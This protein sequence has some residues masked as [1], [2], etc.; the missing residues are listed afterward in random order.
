VLDAGGGLMGLM[1][2]M[3]VCLI[4]E[5]S[6]PYAVGGTSVWTQQLIE[7]LSDVDFT[8]VAI[9]SENKKEKD[10]RYALPGNVRGVQSVALHDQRWLSETLRKRP[11]GMRRA[12]P[13]WDAAEQA[14][15]ALL[16]G[17][18][19]AFPQ[20]NRVVNADLTGWDLFC[21]PRHWSLLERYYRAL[22]PE[23]PFLSFYSMWR[24]SHLLL[25]R[26]LI[27]AMPKDADIYHPIS[28]GFA[29]LLGVCAKL[30]NKG[31]ALILT[32]HGHYS[33]ERNLELETSPWLR[34]YQRYFMSGLFATL[35]RLAYAHADLLVTR[36]EAA[37]RP[38]IEMGAP[39][40]HTVV[41]PNG[42]DSERFARLPARA[43]DGMVRI[44]LIGRVVP[45][46]DVIAF[47]ECA[48][49]VAETLPNAEFEIIGP[50]DDAP[51]YASSARALVRQ[52]RLEDRLWFSGFQK[53][54]V[55]LPRLDL[56]VMSSLKESQP[57]SALEAMAYGIPVIAT[58]AGSLPQMLDGVGELVWQHDIQGMAEAVIRLS[59]DEAR[60]RSWGQ[61][62]GERVRQ[63]YDQHRNLDQYRQLYKQVAG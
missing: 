45:I 29:G 41:V 39:E 53:P 8:V 52:L 58:R 7:T 26:L 44:G 13:A 55:Y 34:G 54:E 61:A 38:P 17:D 47:I 42:V 5:G 40:P 56:V 21:S 1:S 14:Y 28:A 31:K 30:A 9:C 3:H 22:A 19:T 16:R 4:T 32:E 10:R 23:E 57:L 24:S 62:A 20:L 6:Y 46:K 2:R 50:T 59:R 48:K 37:P 15:S 27:T 60:R 18:L 11:S 51:E 43:R 36:I 35:S 63:M 12:R 33:S 25:Y 49:V